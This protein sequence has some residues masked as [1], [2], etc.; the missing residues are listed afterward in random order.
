MV[1]MKEKN[2]TPEVELI[3]MEISSLIDCLS[4]AEFKPLVIRMLRELRV[5][6]N[7]KGRNEGYTK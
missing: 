4:D 1:Q 6:Q 7:R 3:K 5:R 2:K